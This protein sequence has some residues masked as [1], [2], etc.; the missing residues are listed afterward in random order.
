MKKKLKTPTLVTTA[1]L[2]LITVVFWIAFEVIRTVTT[3]PPPTVPEEIISPL[4]PTLDENTLNKLQ[5]RINLSEGQTGN[6]VVSEA[7]ATPEVTATPEA[8]ATVTAT[9]SAS[10]TPVALPSGTP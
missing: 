5:Q 8:T 9:A 10:A 3:K 4:N 6:L 2:T 1:I 7:T